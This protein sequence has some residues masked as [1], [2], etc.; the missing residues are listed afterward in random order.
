MLTPDLTTRQAG[1]LHEHIVRLA[2]SLDAAAIYR[3]ADR[4]AGRWMMTLDAG[5]QP[6]PSTVSALAA[7]YRTV[8]VE[9]VAYLAGLAQGVRIGRTFA[10]GPKPRSKWISE[11]CR[12]LTEASRR[13][14]QRY[15]RQL[16]HAERRGRGSIIATGRRFGGAR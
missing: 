3:D 11:E 12:R 4:F 8:R 13:D 6:A 16:G 2:G 14:V 1:T 5:P 7:E 10:P 9:I 15:I